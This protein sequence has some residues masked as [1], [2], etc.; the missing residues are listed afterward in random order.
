MRNSTIEIQKP[1]FYIR[2][3]EQDFKDL[4]MWQ[5]CLNNFNRKSSIHEL[6]TATS[7]YLYFYS[8]AS[9]EGFGGTYGKHWIQGEWPADWRLYITILELYPIFLLLQLFRAKLVNSR[10]IFHC[11]NK[12]IIEIINKQTS[13]CA[14]TM[15]IIRPMVLTLLHN[16]IFYPT[17]ISGKDDIVCDALSCKLVSPQ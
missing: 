15:K 6:H 13:K 9:K 5:T 4:Q 17:H 16:I 2:I 8:D 7:Q 14:R 11:D 1:H 3:T 12:A 10:I